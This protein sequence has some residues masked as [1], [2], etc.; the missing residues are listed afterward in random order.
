MEM[1]KLFGREI[2]LAVQSCCRHIEEA[3]EPEVRKNR[4]SREEVVQSGVVKGQDDARDEIG[5]Q[6]Q[7]PRIDH[8][9]ARRLDPFEMPA[10]GIGM[11]STKIA[12]LVSGDPVIDQKA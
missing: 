1:Y 5:R 6:G 3:R 9:Y 10:K 7:A 2:A 4:P 8:R 12:P 11:N